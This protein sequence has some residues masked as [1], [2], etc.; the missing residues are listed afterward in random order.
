MLERFKG[1]KGHRRLVEVFADQEIVLHNSDLAKQLAV[2]AVLREYKEGEYLYIEGQPGSNKLYFILCGSFDILIKGSPIKAVKSGEAL[3][4]FPILDPSLSYTVTP[5]AREA[6][7]VATID[8]DQFFS[9]AEQYPTIWKNITKSL[10]TRLHKTNDLIPYQKK[11]CVFIGHG[12]SSLWERVQ[13]FLQNDCNLQRVVA[14]ETE[15]HAGESIVTILQ[16]ILRK[17]TFAILV[18]TGEDE[19]AEGRRRARQNVIHEAGLFQGVLGFHR[20]ILLVQKG[21]EEFSNVHGLQNIV[22]EG[23]RIENTFL[24]LQRVLKREKQIV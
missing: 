5:R 11:P 22:F 18:L 19:T 8:E 16:Q 14:F 23:D 6:S 20:A 9:L 7:I 3:G 15:S 10:V 17:A 13:L 12:H 2:L 4:E 21:L 24:E 1:Q